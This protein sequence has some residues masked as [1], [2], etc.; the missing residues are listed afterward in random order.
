MQVIET[1]NRTKRRGNGEGSNYQRA[2]SRWEAVISIGYGADGKRKRRTVYGW[3][4]KEVQDKLTKL[5]SNKLNGTLGVVWVAEPPVQ[6]CT[7]Q[8]SGV[9]TGSPRARNQRETDTGASSVKAV[10]RQEPSN[11]SV[12]RV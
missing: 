4:K 7:A 1:R 10:G 9:A 11:T 12:Y 2:N 3:T 8:P 6:D 5:Q